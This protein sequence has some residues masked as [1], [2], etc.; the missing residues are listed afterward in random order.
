MIQ[1]LTTK[2]G[3]PLHL[4][5]ITQQEERHEGHEANE[6]RQDRQDPLALLDHKELATWKDVLVP[7]GNEGLLA[8]LDLLDLPDHLDC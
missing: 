8:H 3:I 2:E 5:T 1:M 4:T 7:K 6:D